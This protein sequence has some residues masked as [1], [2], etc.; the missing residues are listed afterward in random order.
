MK[1]LISLLLMTAG[2]TAA[3]AQS[4]IYPTAR[5]I[6]HTDTYGGTTVNDP[7]RWLEDDRSAETGE[8]VK[9]QNKVTFGYL[10]QI[11]YRKQ[12]QD[13]LEKIYNYPKYSAP[14]RKGDWFYFS[15]NDGLQNQ[16]V[17]Y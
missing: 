4:L 9:A 12:L 3:L 13:R 14:S 17:L 15:K 1:H 7:Y 16:S 8:W 6:D 11:P 2:T 10:E 5:K